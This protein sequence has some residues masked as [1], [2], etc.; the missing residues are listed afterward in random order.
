MAWAG[1][2]LMAVLALLGAG[3]AAATGKDVVGDWL[4][5]AEDN[6]PLVAI[7]A[8]LTPDGRVLTYGSNNAGALTQ[9]TGFFIYD[10]WDPSAG[11]SGGHTTLNNYTL[12]DTF[13]SAQVLLPE[14]GDVFLAGGDNWDGTAVTGAGNNNT[15]LFRYTDNT[16]TRGN[17]M[18]KPRWYATTTVMPNGEIYIQGGRDGGAYPEVRQTDGSFRQLNN[19]STAGIHWWYPRNFLAPDGRVFGWDAKYGYMYYVTTDG[20]GTLT[21][22]GTLPSAYQKYWSSPVMFRPGKILQLGGASKDVGIIDI[23]GPTPVVTAAKPM[24]SKRKWVTATVLA[25]G[26]VLATGGSAVPNE[27]T[28]VNNKAEIWN[29][30]TGNWTVGPSGSRPRLYHSTALLLPDASVLVAG[31]GTPGPLTNLYAEIYYPPYL[32]DS[33]GEFASRPSIT[34]APDTLNVNETFSMNVD[35][36]NVSRVTLVRTGAVTHSF[37]MDQRFLELSFT[38][39]SGTLF[40]QT[41]A[42]LNIAPP[43]YYLLFVFNNQGVPS[44]GKIVRININ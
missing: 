21:R 44:V 13:C 10:V 12:T 25:D 35:A 37:N 16:L 8:V 20:A 15:N 2:V 36:S 29:P 27:L 7:H 31:G 1:R 32:Y 34:Y 11:L 17:N 18:Y 9:Q 40:V 28:G 6:W 24:S 33:S 41:P 42:N 43:G 23:N 39:G 14:S 22:V 38:D 3:S 19:A 26:R 4:S 5:P 30:D